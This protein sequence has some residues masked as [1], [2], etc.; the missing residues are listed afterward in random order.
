MVYLPSSFLKLIINL[1]FPLLVF[2]EIKVQIPWL[3]EN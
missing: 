3:T 1:S 2:R